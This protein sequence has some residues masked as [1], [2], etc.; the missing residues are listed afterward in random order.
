MLERNSVYICHNLRSWYSHLGRNVDI[1]RSHKQLVNFLF[2]KHMTVIESF[3][4]PEPWCAWFWR[5]MITS[6]NIKCLNSVWPVLTNRNEA[7]WLA[8]LLP[9][10]TCCCADQSQVIQ[11]LSFIKCG[12]QLVCFM[13][14]SSPSIVYSFMLPKGVRIFIK[15][16]YICLLWFICID[17]SL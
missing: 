10:L 7:T 2:T 12:R 15:I 1:V 14:C 17:D 11:S 8:N 13:G 9:P 5:V 4:I 3:D 16:G 6:F